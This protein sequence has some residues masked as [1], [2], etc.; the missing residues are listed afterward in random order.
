MN[1]DAETIRRII[2][3]LIILILSIAVHEFGHAYVADK[4]GDR[5]PRSQGRLTLNPIAHADPFGTLLFPL[6]GLVFSQ[7]TSY[8]FGW[9]RPVEVNPSSF[10]RKY[11][12]RTSHLFVAAAGP[13]MNVLFGTLIAIIHVSLVYSGTLDTAHPMSHALMTAAQLNFILCFFNLVPAPPL[14]GGTVIAGLLPD[15]W[16]PQYE[17]IAVYGPFILLAFIFTPLKIIFIAPAIFCVQHLYSGLASLAQ[18][19]F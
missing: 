14:D 15:R 12:V 17:K 1:L 18:L 6:I 19:V 11:R 9:G 13:A 4:L 10:T 2:E 3:G 7:G 16:V 8:G 5:L